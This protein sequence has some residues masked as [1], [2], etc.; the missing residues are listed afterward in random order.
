MLTASPIYFVASL[1][2][3]METVVVPDDNIF[4]PDDIKCDSSISEPAGPV[5]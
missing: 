3:P 5:I 2:L 1:L 4:P